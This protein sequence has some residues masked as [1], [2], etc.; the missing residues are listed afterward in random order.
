[1]DAGGRGSYE[2]SVA[3]TFVSEAV[4]RV[5]DRSIQCGGLGVPH[6]APL[7]RLLNEVR[8]FRIYDGPAETHRWSIARREVRRL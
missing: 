5:V 2:A 1:M 7:G 6:E 3:K 8:A 4:F